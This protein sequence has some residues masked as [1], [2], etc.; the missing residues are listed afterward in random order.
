[1]ADEP[2]ETP[3][4]EAET[5]PATEEQPKA[6]DLTGLKSALETERTQRKEF[7]KELKALR[8]ADEK[9][10]QESMSETEKAIAQAKAEGHAEATKAAG[11]KLAAAELKAA[12]KDEQLN[13]DDVQDFIKVDLFVDENGDVDSKAIKKAVAAFAKIAPAPA[14]G[15]SGAPLPGGSGGR[16]HT[17]PTLD[18]AVAA[19][20]GA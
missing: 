11:K 20:Y 1:M 12:A 3:A 6:E 10:Q 16:H 17:N 15:R 8:A 18:S 13:L 4:P 5:S 19:H 7:E 9:R 2:T 14:P